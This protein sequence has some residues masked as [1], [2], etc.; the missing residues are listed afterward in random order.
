M[1][2]RLKHRFFPTPAGEN[3][4]FPGKNLDEIRKKQSGT[5]Y[6]GSRPLTA[7]EI[8][9]L[10]ANRCSAEDWK[11][12]SVID[13]F[14]PDLVKDSVF[15]GVVRIGCI[16]SGLL[17]DNERSYRCGI[18]SSRIVSSDIGNYCAIHNNSYISA[19]ITGDYVILTD[20]N[21][22]YT[23]EKASFGNCVPRKG[24]RPESVRKVN[25]VNERG[26]RSVLFF[27]GMTGADILLW[28]KYRGNRA[29]TEKL[30]EMTFRTF[31]NE[32]GYYS[33]F[34]DYTV[35]KGTK[36]VRNTMTGRGCRIDRACRVDE[37][38]VNSSA[39]NPSA[40][41][42]N[43]IACR[44]IAGG[45]CRIESGSV[46]EDFMLAPG[47]ALRL[48]ARFLHSYL[49]SGSNI[50]CCE[51]Q[52]SFIFPCHEQHHNNS[53][54]IASVIMGQS[55][56]A[57]GA[58][59]GSNHNGRMNDCEM[60]AGR[61]F[62]PGLCS[63][64]RFNSKFA[65]FCLLA[66]SDFPYELDIKLPFSLVSNNPAE[67][68]LE[69]IP[70]YWWLYNMYALFRNYFKFRDRSS[71]IKAME[72]IELDFMAPDTA[73]EVLSAVSLIEERRKKASVIETEFRSI[74]IELSSS[75]IEG[76]DRMVKILRVDKAERAYR[77][78]LVFYCGSVIFSFT[79]KAPGNLDLMLNGSFSPAR[80]KGWV[81]MCGHLVPE[82]SLSHII[83]MISSA[84]PGQ[85]LSSWEEVHD[86]FE[87]EYELYE[88]RKLSH[89]VSVAL[90]LYGEE[91][92]DIRFLEK[93]KADYLDILCKI[94]NEIKR[95]RKKDF[96]DPL[97]RNLFSGPGEMDAVLGSVEDDP[98]PARFRKH[99]IESLPRLT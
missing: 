44:G 94:E 82:K 40:I 17:E 55:N 46:A 41:L 79:S 28:V 52:S 60:W 71:S 9:K 15:E 23:T 74:N 73:E 4:A 26:G 63:S 13:P 48:G 30:A 22:I 10:E 92:P 67:N 87:N 11:L 51:V 29:F 70:A 75:G 64:V 68:C 35:I 86:A 3:R 76:S 81:N 37:V 98:L 38:T 56:I 97:R 6:N 1:N 27:S 14:D 20:N 57:A 24:D 43:S 61:G 65:S 84:V 16:E 49:G 32:C 45:G 83:R 31:D 89:A 47:S 72:G 62:W 80:E 25:I 5:R 53:F 91:T 33:F 59:L 42:D 99:F 66:K 19:V 54:L 50:S 12:L 58:T 2:E 36:L 85:V 90:T 95:T 7:D 77:E 34:D 39:G 93:L 18:S 96:D 69:I 88:S 78:M 8:K 21:E